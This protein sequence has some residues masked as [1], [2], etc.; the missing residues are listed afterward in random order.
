M[1]PAQQK[2]HQ[3]VQTHRAASK[4]ELLAAKLDMRAVNNLVGLGLIVVKGDVYSTPGEAEANTL[5]EV[6]PAAPVEL[7]DWAKEKQPYTGSAAAKKALALVVP[8]PT[9]IA[10]K[11]KPPHACLCGCGASVSGRFKQGHDM[12]LHQQVNAAKKASQKFAASV[13]QA[14]W[15]GTKA[16]A[17]GAYEVTR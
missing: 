11:V 4:A 1:T 8:E 17:K 13:E 15:L 16:W 12:K 6:E 14:E 2:A 7:P 10:P 5:V 9:R 3:F